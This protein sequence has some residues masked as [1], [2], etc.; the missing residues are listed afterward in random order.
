MSA[1]QD[2]YSDR[3]SLFG[4]LPTRMM[5]WAV[6]S[7]PRMP[8]A[9][10]WFLMHASVG[11]IFILAGKQRRAIRANLTHIHGDLGVWRS[12]SR[13][14][15]VILNFG[16]TYL[17]SMRAKLGQNS[18]T[19]ELVG[20]EVFNEIRDSKKAAILFITHTGNYD[21]AA[22]LFASEFGR[23]L[24]TVRV[25]ERTK[26]LQKI[27]QREFDADMEKYPFFK[28]HYNTS[29]SLLGVELARLLSQ[30]ELIAL[31][32]DRVIGNVVEMDIPLNGDEDSGDWLM[33]VPKGPM[34]LAC[35]G[36]CP[37]Y[38]LYVVRDRHRHYRVIFEPALDVDTSRPRLREM[39][40]AKPW[41]ARLRK[42]LSH[43]S[44]EWFVFEEAFIKKDDRA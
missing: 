6:R 4:D 27:R 11:V 19:W 30:G 1:N 32:C 40:Y 38:P 33:R 42:F 41:V 26:K 7:F 17:D 16:W 24:H 28:V 34:T 2:S 29:E 37:C 14:F 25:P 12:Y 35:V 15:S 21:L 18:I 23:T 22:C 5:M 10:E 20:E 36:K 39:D 31:Q 8:Y 44:H 3:W 43:H 13:A 9:I